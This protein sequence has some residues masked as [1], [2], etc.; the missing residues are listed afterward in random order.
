M[1]ARAEEFGHFALVIEDD[2]G[3]ALR[4]HGDEI[5]GDRETAQAMADEWNDYAAVKGT[6]KRF[7]IRRLCA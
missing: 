3:T 5:Y 1:S 7:A 6:G 4:V 2:E